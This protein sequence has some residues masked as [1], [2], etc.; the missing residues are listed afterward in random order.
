MARLCGGSA[1]AGPAGEC[2][3]A[4]AGGDGCHR[5]GVSPDTAARSYLSPHIPLLPPVFF[6]AGTGTIPP[7]RKRTSVPPRP[8][9]HAPQGAYVQLLLRVLC[10]TAECMQF[11]CWCGCPN[12][13]CRVVSWRAR[14][15]KHTLYCLNMLPQHTS[16]SASSPTA[17]GCRQPGPCSHAQPSSAL[18][19][20]SG[21]TACAGAP[22]AL[23]PTAAAAA[24]G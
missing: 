11:A 18:S 12:V 22:A 5:G 17:V 14:W 4:V 16:A 3:F 7:S 6:P 9:P 8:C 21:A 23:A 15:H 10:P 13:M 24:A 19:W 2:V 20:R 1:P